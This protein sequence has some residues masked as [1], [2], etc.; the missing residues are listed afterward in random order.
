MCENVPVLYIARLDE[1]QRPEERVC[2]S[3]TSDGCPFRKVAVCLQH[4][5]LHRTTVFFFIFSYGDEIKMDSL[6]AC[7]N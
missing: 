7:V 2:L 4:R 1:A 5:L 3:S 6:L